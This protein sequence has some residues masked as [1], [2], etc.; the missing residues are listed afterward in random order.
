MTELGAIHSLHHLFNSRIVMIFS[1]RVHVD[2][3]N[4]PWA[5]ITYKRLSTS[6]ADLKTESGDSGLISEV[7][8]P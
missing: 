3:C 1:F 6:D 4:L 5:S 2:S 7:I 8:D